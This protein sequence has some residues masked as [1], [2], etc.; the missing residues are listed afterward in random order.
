[1]TA[2]AEP[3]HRYRIEGEIARGSTAAILRARDLDLGREV[4]IKVLL[5][6]HTSD[7]EVVGRFVAEAQIAAQLQHPGIA[8]IHDVGRFAGSQPYFVMKLVKGRTLADILAERADPL[9]E[10]PRLLAVFEMV[11]QTMA[12]AHAKGVIHRNLNPA[13]VM[14]GA[15]GEV[16]VMDWGLAKVLG[17]RPRA[18]RHGCRG[19]S[20][21]VEGLTG[22]LA[23][24]RSPDVT[25]AGAVLGTP[26][27]MAPEQARGEFNQL[28][29][30]SD[31]FGLGAILCEILTGAP[32]FRS[33]GGLDLLEQT[34]AADLSDA[35]DRLD[36]CGADAE[37]VRLAKDCLAAEPAARPADGGA[38]AK[39][40]AKYLAGAQEQ[41]RR[42]ELERAWAQ[43]RT[44]G[45][46]TRRRLAVGLAAAV[47]A[48]V[49]LAARTLLAQVW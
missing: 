18:P 31:V 13:N 25:Q 33:A 1:M 19:R 48:V 29:E 26:T 15:F 44:E 27:Y 36:R 30:R 17:E 40:L 45:E 2:A 14:V 20:P 6:P 12:Y 24:L 4:V 34:R 47:L 10:R 37:L 5:E 3:P 49:A 28:D 8:P 43:G 21:P 41:L 16:Q 42:A 35:V 11:C 38:V 7:S 32:P 9:Q 46:R 39:R 22:G 23:P